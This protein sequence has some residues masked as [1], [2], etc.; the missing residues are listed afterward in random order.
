MKYRNL[1]GA[2]FGL[3]FCLGVQ[4]SRAASSSETA[5]PELDVTIS[6][7]DTADVSAVSLDAEMT[8]MIPASDDAIAVT[9]TDELNVSMGNTVSNWTESALERLTIAASEPEVIE[10]SVADLNTEMTE[11]VLPTVDAIAVTTIDELSDV[12]PTDWAYPAL[13]SLVENYS[14]IEGYPDETY[15]GDRFLTRY[16]FAALLDRCLS[17]VRSLAAEGQVPDTDLQTIQR[18]QAEYQ[19]ELDA[20]TS[21]VEALETETASLRATTFSTTTRL[22]GEVVFSLEHLAGGDQANGSG[23]DL[24]EALVFGSRARLNFNTSFTGRDLLKIRLDALDPTRFTAPVTGTNM[25]RL[26]FDRTNNNDFDIGKFFYRFPVGDR[27]SLHIDFTRGAYQANVSSTFNPGLANPISGAVSRFGRFNPIYY[28]GALGTGITGVY[29]IA[30]NLSFSAGYLSRSPG[31][32]NPDDGGLFGSG[33]TALAQL[34]Y[35][36]TETWGLGLVYARSYY[37][38][39][40]IAVSA[41]TGSRLANAPFGRNVAT[42][43]NHFGVQSSLKLGS[44]TLSGWTGLSLA[45]AESD[46]ALVSDGD[47]ATM[48]NWAVTLGLPNL[49]GQGNFGGLVVGNPPRV[50]SNDGGADEEDPTWHIEAFYRYRVNQNIALV[51]GFFVLINPENNSDNDTIW[52]GSL[53]AVFQF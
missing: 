45:T 41:G 17:V 4:E 38:A 9:P 18:L 15:R 14:C 42:S 29:D 47:S 32:N 33:Y 16:E 25:T 53:R 20:L 10:L 2:A 26:A 35:R 8:E 28:Q 5:V 46:S 34:D 30:P 27:L 3:A 19:S 37:P 23:N 52:V 43:A 40:A 22:R 31:S 44:A 1:V 12:S 11:T 6:D 49:G 13:Q 51:P 36:P 48:L 39:G 21:R 24:S 7:T 50:L